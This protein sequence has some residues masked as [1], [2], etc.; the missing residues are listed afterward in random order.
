MRL[1]HLWSPDGCGS[2]K[3]DSMDDRLGIRD[4]QVTRN[5]LSREDERGEG[6]GE[7]G[8]ESGTLGKSRRQSPFGREQYSVSPR[9][10]VG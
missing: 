4:S 8:P 5:S 10:A 9:A 1:I 2:L 6:T 3:L 7:S